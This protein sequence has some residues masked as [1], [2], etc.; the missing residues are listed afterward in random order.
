MIRTALDEYQQD[1]K[2]AVLEKKIFAELGASG[3][4]KELSELVTGNDWGGLY[5]FKKKYLRRIPRDPFDIYGDGWG[6]RAY[7]DEPDSSFWSGSDVYDIYSQSNETALD[8]TYY[9]DW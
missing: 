8:G 7:E 6:L 4:P 3:Y 1:Y 9:R 5:P 2:K